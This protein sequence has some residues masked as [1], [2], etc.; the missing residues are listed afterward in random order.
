MFRTV[1]GIVVPVKWKKNNQIDSVSIQATDEVEYR[2]AKGE[3]LRELIRLCGFRVRV[4]GTV[5]QKE[6]E[7]LIHVERVEQILAE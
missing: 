4:S 6:R 5:E 2:V 1:V 3:H 7:T